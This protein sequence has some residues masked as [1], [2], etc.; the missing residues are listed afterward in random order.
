[1]CKVSLK[2]KIT[3]GVLSPLVVLMILTGLVSVLP[4]YVYYPRWLDH[5]INKM[6]D[7]QLDSI[8]NVSEILAQTISFSLIQLSVNFQ[9]IFG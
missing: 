5:Y 1:M 7:D 4:L 9:G 8:L 2:N 6:K 3:L